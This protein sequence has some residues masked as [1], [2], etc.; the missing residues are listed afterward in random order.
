MLSGFLRSIRIVVAKIVA[1]NAYGRRLV[2]WLWERK[3]PGLIH[4]FDVEYGIDTSGILPVQLI[5]PG[6]RADGEIM[7]YAGCQP[8]CVREAIGAVGSLD[9]A[10]FWDLGCG[11]GR[12]LVIASEFPFRQ[13]VGVELSLDLCGLARDNA[14]IVARRHPNRPP[15]AVH[16]GDAL[17]APLPRGELVVFLYH[18]FGRDTLSRILGRLAEATQENDIWIIYE[19]PVYGDLIDSCS[20]FV[21]W[22][23]DQVP[24]GVD[25]REYHFDDDEAVV[26]WRSAIGADRRA[27]DRFQKDFDIV[28]T[29]PG[30]RAEIVMRDELK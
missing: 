28:I 8:N 7:F 6:A 12:A 22:W 25:E 5:S 18:P 14:A 24:C 30:L 15:I 13:I 11:K 21:R 9:D 23:A 26:V 17:A 10:T 3:N 1:R 29:K 4:P 27:T 19:N 2:I 16:C 20:V